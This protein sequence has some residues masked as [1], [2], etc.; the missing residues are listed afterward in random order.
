MKAG[1]QGRTFR[2]SVWL[3]AAL[4]LWL[5]LPSVRCACRSAS[6]NSP[7]ESVMAVRCDM[8]CCQ[9]SGTPC[10]CC[11]QDSESSGSN[12]VPSNNSPCD[13]VVVSA[14]APTVAHGPRLQDLTCGLEELCLV[15]VCPPSTSAI[16]SVAQSDSG[17]V[18]NRVIVYRH[19]LI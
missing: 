16:P 12:Q 11:C 19:L 8:P 7:R 13:K 18:I 1:R 14:D 3:I 10:C 6:K 15:L 17:P 2:A 9:G 4:S 5:G